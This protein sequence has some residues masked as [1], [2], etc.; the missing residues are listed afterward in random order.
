MNDEQGLDQKAIDDLLAN[1]SKELPDLNETAPK[2]EQVVDPQAVT[3]ESISPMPETPVPE[4]LA[5]QTALP[6]KDKITA[7]FKTVKQHTTKKRILL[8]VSLFILVIAGSAFIGYKLGTHRMENQDP[9][10][11]IISQGITL[12]EKNFVMVA[13]HG[14]KE[15]VTAFLET[16]MSIDS[17]RP[18]DGWSPLMAAS[19]YKKA[20]VVKLLLEKDAAVNIQDKYGKTALMQASAMGAEDVV[21]LL[22]TYGANPNLQDRNGRTA[23]MEAYSKNQAKVAEMLKAA[24]AD[25]SIQPPTAA[26]NPTIPPVTPKDLIAPALPSPTEDPTRLTIGK[27]GFVEIGMPL[28]EIQKKYPTVTL[29]QKFLNGSKKPV[30]T[31]YVNGPNSPALE[32]EL[33]NS[34]LKLVS[35]ISTVADQFATDKQISIKSTVGDIRNQYSI[36]EVKVIDNSLYLSVKSM[37]MLFE[38]NISDESVLSEW[39]KTGNIKDIPEDIKIKRIIIY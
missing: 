35:T 28:A 19:F 18:S 23:L 39:F 8:I 3:D 4:A 12:E 38:L 6:L 15:M 16:G 20:D 37:K 10:E 31:V 2:T 26:K 24:G 34:S 14:E 29:S 33:S 17:L 30:A 25:P 27:V 5:P 1:A 9:L 22:L 32:L 36:T 13:A 11:K 21:S 7:F